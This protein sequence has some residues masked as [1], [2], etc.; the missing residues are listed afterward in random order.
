MYVNKDGVEIPN[1]DPNSGLYVI[2][3]NGKQVKVAFPKDHLAFQIGET[4]QIHSGGLLQA[5]PH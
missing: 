4:A 3:R 1:P 5:T 2:S